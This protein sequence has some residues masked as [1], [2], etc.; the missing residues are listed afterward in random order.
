MDSGSIPRVK[1]H[2]FVSSSN[3]THRGE[4][5]G[6][7]LK[8]ALIQTDLN[9]LKVFHVLMEERNVTRAADRLFVSQSAISKS[10]KRLREIFDDAL[11]VR[12]AH[13]LVPT[14]RA[15]ELAATVRDAVSRLEG[16]WEAK[17]FD[18]AEARG[19]VRI[20]APEQFLVGAATNL[21]L[22]LRKAAPC[23]GIEWLHLMD[24]YL[25]ALSAGSMDFAIY[26]DQPYPEGFVSRRVLSA[27]PRIWF[28]K[29]HPLS[30]KRKLELT[31]ICAYPIIS[32]HSPNVTR[33]D[34]RSLLD[35]M[36]DEGL[37]KTLLTSTSHLVIALEMLMKTD[38]IMMGP[39][40]VNRVSGFGAAIA[41]RSVNHLSAFSHLSDIHMS[42][43]QHERTLD[44]PLH[45]WLASEIEEVYAAMSPALEASGIT[46]ASLVRA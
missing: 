31:D 4:K 43:I 29:R 7:A 35:A 13:G 6:A 33:E 8:K 44:S 23:L 39:E 14:T 28:N 20:A 36:A 40:Y 45:C 26:L 10:L 41:A 1:L 42:L 19:V 38:A 17:P 18:P 27:A 37:S 11:L 34:I 30:A 22:R 24:D 15:E 32:F 25:A 2:L 5:G 3:G 21:V 46:R 12:S 9:L 16:L